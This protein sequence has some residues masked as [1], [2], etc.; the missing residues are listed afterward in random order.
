MSA[1]GET[2]EHV[3][4]GMRCTWIETSASSA[5]RVVVGEMF[6]PSGCPMPPAHVHPHQEERLR[7]VAGAAIVT[8]AGRQRR[9][10]A[11]DEA[12]IPAGVAHTFVPAGDADLTLVASASPAL[13][14]DRFCALAWTVPCDARGRPDFLRMALVMNRFPGHLYLAGPP[15]S[16]QKAVFKVAAAVARLTGRSLPPGAAGA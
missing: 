8:I 4:L 6:V 16:L 2:I 9:M 11:S 10:E 12:V 5:G 13:G 3:N 15:V 7:V 14:W 1:P